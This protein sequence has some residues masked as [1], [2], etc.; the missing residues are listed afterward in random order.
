MAPVDRTSFVIATVALV[1]ACLLAPVGAS[2]AVV[3]P[4]LRSPDA[5][6]PPA[7]EGGSVQ[8][9]WGGT[10]QGDADAI[11]RSFFRVEL[12]AAAN[13]PGGAQTAWS[14]DKIE[15]FVQTEP[16][17]TVSAASMGVPSAGEYRWRV[18]AWG[19]VDASVNNVIQQLPGG[20]SPSRALTTVAAS[21]A[22][23]VPGELKLEER[24]QVAGAVRTVTVERPSQETVEPADDV[25]EEAVEEIEEEVPPA[26]FQD[27]GATTIEAN[28]RSALS[29]VSAAD[30]VDHAAS[31]T[32]E[33]GGDAGV[34]GL[35]VGALGT[36]LPLVPIPFWTLA[37]LL[38]IV[39]ILRTWR[40]SVL[41]MFEWSDG[42]I[43][44]RGTMPSTSDD[45]VPVRVASGIKVGST[46]ADGDEHALAHESDPPA[47][48]REGGRLAA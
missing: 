24:R 44:G 26:T 8:F 22:A 46:T 2:A 31:R 20:C 16:G 21:S 29:G 40:R 13:A 5:K 7:V 19:V 32:A 48:A 43:D 28:K 45:L 1:A 15:N 6:A 36:S 37:I 42:S 18:C 41:E 9:E 39:P 27:V 10:L 17:A 38:A 3:A 14:A 30:E 47:R 35:L 23:R 33:R 11:D 12:I 4:S 25:V 34:T